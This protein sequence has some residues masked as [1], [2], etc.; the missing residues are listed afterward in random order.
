MNEYQKQSV[1]GLTPLQLVVR[2]YD[3]AIAACRA[4]DRKRLRSVVAE[5]MS[6][7]DME[8]GG[9][10]YA[11]SKRRMSLAIDKKTAEENGG[12]E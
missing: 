5:L 9:D 12:G 1:L 4:G 8:N 11:E 6:A 3:L 2:M 7:L 10:L